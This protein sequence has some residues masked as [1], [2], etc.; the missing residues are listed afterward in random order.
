MNGTRESQLAVRNQLPTMDSRRGL[1]EVMGSS[2]DVPAMGHPDGDHDRSDDLNIEGIETRDDFA[3]MLR[4]FRAR[5]ATRY[6]D[7]AELTYG[8]IVKKTGYSQ[9]RSTTTSRARLCPSAASRETSSRSASGANP[10]P[11]APQRGR[12]T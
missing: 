3:A 7:G 1:A 10:S 2:V 5:H 11:V 9:G 8:Q 12:L 6:N 4:R